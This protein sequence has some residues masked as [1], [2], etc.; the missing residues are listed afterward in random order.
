MKDWL[1]TLAPRER[2]MVLVCAVVVAITLLWLLVWKPLDSRHDAL[3]SSVS[4]WETGLAQ[5]QRVAELRGSDSS[6]GGSPNPGADQTPVIIVDTTLR[7][8]GL[9]GALR[10][11]QPTTSTGIRVEFENVAFNSLV[12]WLGDLSNRYG[13][14]VQAGTLS[15]PAQADPGRIN[16]T[17]TLERNL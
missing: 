8:R 11:S 3:R 5:L 4:D 10:R 9:S 14:D 17:L 13:M 15:V 12:L 7:A 1:D 16:A 6:A 2:I